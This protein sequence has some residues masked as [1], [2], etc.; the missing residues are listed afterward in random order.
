LL[1]GRF[2]PFQQGRTAAHE[3][4]QQS[5]YTPDSSTPLKPK[6]GIKRE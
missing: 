3:T 1:N 6:N 5:S 4:S 2:A